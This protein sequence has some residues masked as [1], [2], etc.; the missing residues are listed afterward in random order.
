M[1]FEWKLTKSQQKSYIT[2]VNFT[3]KL[4]KLAYAYWWIQPSSLEDLKNHWVHTLMFWF[5]IFT[6]PQL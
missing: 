2:S 3:W 1:K 5:A 4:V 6:F